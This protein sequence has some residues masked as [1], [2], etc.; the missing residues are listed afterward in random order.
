MSALRRLPSLVCAL[1]L[2]AL[3]SGAQAGASG[4]FMPVGQ[5]GTFV[6][7]RPG[8]FGTSISA[9]S[10]RIAVGTPHTSIP[11]TPSLPDVG[12][13]YIH[14]FQ[15]GAW[16]ENSYSIESPPP[17]FQQ[18]GMEF[19][20]AVAISGNDMIVG[21]PGEN[22]SSIVDAGA[23]YF[24][25]RD[26]EGI[27]Q[28]RDRS[29]SN[30]VQTGQR[31][32]ASVAITATYAA[33]GAPG[34]NQDSQTVD[35]G[36]VT[37]YF[38]GSDAGSYLQSGGELTPSPQGFEAFGSSLHF[39]DFASGTDRL[40]IGA[41]NRDVNG[42][43]FTGSAYFYERVGGAWDLRQTF[44]PVVGAGDFGGSAIATNGDY[45][46]VGARGRDAP[47]GMGSAGSVR[48]YLMGINGLYGFDD[49]L[50][51]SDAQSSAFFGSAIAASATRL[52]VGAPTH[53][54]GA[55]NSGR[56]Y[57]FDRQTLAGETLYVQIGAL[58]LPNAPANNDQL[59]SAVAAAASFV[60]AAA[61]QRDI[62]INGTVYVD[63]GTSSE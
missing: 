23:V 38:R 46:F 8:E 28:F 31:F 29:D 36:R 20:A 15:N 56:A 48:V 52:V 30:I 44:A 1:S 9:S 53:N 16:V 26:A 40:F 6:A 4:P 61:P 51:A 14:R 25:R 22:V 35:T 11:G 60:F 62:D 41:P 47:G 32:G 33:A 12:R 24:Y 42:V 57:V 39:Q 10:G 50:R 37:T 63:A 7:N 3:C 58:A 45:L 27:W 18:S 43:A 49:E 19:G 59:G 34:Y 55:T 2:T 17:Q 13:V 5:L 21:A 54:A